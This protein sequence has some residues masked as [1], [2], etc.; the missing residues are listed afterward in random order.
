MTRAPG[1]ALI[2]DEDG[3]ILRI[4]RDELGLGL[5]LSV[6]A[7][8][9]LVELVPEG[10]QLRTRA[11]LEA[12]R[13]SDAVF[14]CE[15]ITRVSE[16]VVLLRYSGARVRDGFLI[17]AARSQGAVTRLGD[18]F[19]RMNNEAVNAL[20]AVSKR[21][22]QG[23]TPPPATEEAI[24][25]EFTRVNNELANLQREMAKKNIELE[26]VDGER[27]QLLGMVAHDLRNPLGLIATYS[28]FLES[29]TWLSVEQQALVTTIRTT[30]VF[31]LGLVHDLLDISA[32]EAGRLQ[33]A[34]ELCDLGA[35]VAQNTDRNRTLAFRKNIAIDL[36]AP[37]AGPYVRADVGKIHQVLDNLVGNAVKFSQPGARIQVALS[38]AQ[39]SANVAVI[40]RGPGLSEADLRDL[41]TPFRRGSARATGGERSTGLG[42]VIA[43]KIVEGHGGALRVDSALGQ[44]ATFA[45]SLPVTGPTQPQVVRP[46]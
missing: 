19:M 17:I 5:G 8:A 11:F 28:E 10:E 12:L 3:R 31:M 18:E 13:S 41:F 2:C 37:T 43:R 46:D 38:V 20:R 21:L 29:E 1:F 45:F 6:P 32:I 22:S 9:Q 24:F 27:R 39:G 16:G 26:R 4:L 23:A 40:D 42:L 25:A 35:V 44:G 34:L 36:D 15:M 33:L 7:S 30:T 14:D